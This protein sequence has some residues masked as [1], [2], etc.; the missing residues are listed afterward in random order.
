MPVEIRELF[1]KA[2][3][4]NDEDGTKGKTTSGNSNAKAAA[5]NEAVS[6][7]SSSISDEERKELIETIM[8]QVKDYMDKQFIR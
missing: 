6:S 2:F 1:I 3:M 5:L 8:M 7:S 4:D